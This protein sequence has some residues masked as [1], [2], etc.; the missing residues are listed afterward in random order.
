MIFGGNFLL[1]QLLAGRDKIRVL[2]ADSQKGERP[3]LGWLLFPC[4]VK[5]NHT[6]VNTQIYEILAPR[7]DMSPPF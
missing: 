6:A 4:H 5:S 7:D 1:V 2:K 3:V